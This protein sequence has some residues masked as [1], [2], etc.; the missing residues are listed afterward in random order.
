VVG[1]PAGLASVARQVDA[2]QVVMVSDLSAAKAAEKFLRAVCASAVVA[3]GIFA[4]DALDLIRAVKDAPC[5]ARVGDDLCR[6]AEVSL[7]VRFRSIRRADQVKRSAAVDQNLL[8]QNLLRKKKTY[9]RQPRRAFG[10]NTNA[11]DATT[12]SARWSQG[13]LMNSGHSTPGMAFREVFCGRDPRRDRRRRR[14]IL[15]LDRCAIIPG[16]PLIRRASHGPF[17]HKGE[18]GADQEEL[19]S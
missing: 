8:A 10:L 18:K 15:A 16:L 4:V 12:A 13:P 2:S 17:P 7:V 3:K 14:L 11:D 5:V 19:A 9:C 1:A 6:Y